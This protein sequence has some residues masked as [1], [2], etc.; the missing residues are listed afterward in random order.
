LE[1]EIERFPDWLVWHLLISP[2]LEI[3]EATA[4]PL[5]A[6]TYRVRLVAVNSGWLPT[7][8]T[9]IA[10]EKKIV[11]GVVVEIELPEGATLETGQTR[12]ALGQLEGRAYTEAA[13]HIWIADATEDRFKQEWVIKAPQGGQVKLTVRHERAGAARAQVDLK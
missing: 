7:Y 13:A 1:K 5:G 12:V 8:I 3:L 2:K 6:D 4:A 11:R 9:K 10:L